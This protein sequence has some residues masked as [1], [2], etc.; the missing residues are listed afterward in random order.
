MAPPFREVE[1]DILYGEGISREGD[2]VDL[3]AECDVVE[4]SGAWFGFEGERIGQGRENAR[5]YLREH[6]DV[7]KKIES[8]LLAHHGVKR[9][10]GPSAL[11]AG[12]AAGGPAGTVRPMAPQPKAQ[13]PDKRR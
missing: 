13:V 6:P 7:A 10:V 4:K 12:P 2:L 11:S 3:A 1:F 8:K 5:L 9:E